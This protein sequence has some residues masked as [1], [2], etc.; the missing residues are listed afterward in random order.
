MIGLLSSLF[1]ASLKWSKCNSS[2]FAAATSLSGR[3]I[4]GPSRRRKTTVRVGLRRCPFVVQILMPEGGFGLRLD[5]INAWHLYSKWCFES[6]AIAEK[7]SERF[8][9]E[10]VAAVVKAS[11]GGVASAPRRCFP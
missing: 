2:D 4:M 8:G 7:F 9:G 5:A 10:I 11:E 1:Q 6:L 3:N